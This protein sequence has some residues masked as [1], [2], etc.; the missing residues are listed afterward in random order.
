VS[1][2]LTGIKA[3][4]DSPWR[5]ELLLVLHVCV[6]AGSNGALDQV[7]LVE[8][9]ARPS[10]SIIKMMIAP[11][12]PYRLRCTSTTLC[13][14][15]LLFLTMNFG[16]RDCYCVICGGLLWNTWHAISEKPRQLRS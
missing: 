7:R 8:F 2:L 9:T 12:K 4:R 3:G 11:V 14:P 6:E 10:S 16:E 5:P 15:Q 1:F 13:W